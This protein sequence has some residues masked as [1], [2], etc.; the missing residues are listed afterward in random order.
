MKWPDWTATTERLLMCKHLCTCCIT[1]CIWIMNL[2]HWSLHLHMVLRGIEQTDQ[3][4]NFS[5]R[6]LATVIP[7]PNMQ[8]AAVSTHWSL[9]RDPPHRAPR[10]SCKLTCQGQLPGE[11][12]WPPT[13]LVFSEATPHPARGEKSST[14]SS[15]NK[16]KKMPKYDQFCW[17]MSAQSTVHWQQCWVL[18]SQVWPEA[19]C[20][21]FPALPSYSRPAHYWKSRGLKT[22]QN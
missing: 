17:L 2:S 13:I 3:K 9:I 15:S 10:S 12:S 8:W 14:W 19:I 22:P 21:L 20:L 7:H 11:A 6:K 5:K 16:T 1:V 4:Q 18:L